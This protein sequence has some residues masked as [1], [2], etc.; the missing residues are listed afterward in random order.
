MNKHELKLIEFLNGKF[1]EKSIDLTY[2]ELKA[3]LD[4]NVVVTAPYLYD[5]LFSDYDKGK[6]F[7]NK[8]GFQF[9]VTDNCDIEEDNTKELYVEKPIKDQNENFDLAAALLAE[10]YIAEDSA[11]FIHSKTF[12][13]DFNKHSIISFENNEEYFSQLKEDGDDEAFERIVI[14]NQQLVKKIAMQYYNAMPKGGLELDD[15]ISLGQKGLL[16]AIERFDIERGYQFSTYATHWIKQAIS[17]GYADE[18]RIIRLPVHVHDSLNKIRKVI[19][20]K[21][22]DS[23]QL[24]IEDVKAHTDLSEEKIEELLLY[25]HLFNKAQ[26]SLSTYIGEDQDSEIGDFIIEPTEENHAM[27]GDDLVENEVFKKTLTQYINE[28]LNSDFKPREADVIIKRFGLNGMKVMTL[29]EIGEEHGVTRERIRQIEKN[30]LRK[31]SRHQ[32]INNFRDY[33]EAN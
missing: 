33:W 11:E 14:A 5:K 2:E 21:D 8:F 31:L 19:R 9:I 4:K 12:E 16:K 30:V 3:D 17:R 32:V 6:E 23:M 1:P 15:F 27:F 28:L 24:M 26:V 18:S 10:G 7:I 25:D 20:N 22:Y 13:D 29:E